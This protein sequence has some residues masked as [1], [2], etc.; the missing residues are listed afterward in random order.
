MRSLFD[1]SGWGREQMGFTEDVEVL[2]I[3]AAAIGSVVTAGL[4][5]RAVTAAFF[6]TGAHMSGDDV[7]YIQH[8]Q[9]FEAAIAEEALLGMVAQELSAGRA[10]TLVDDPAARKVITLAAAMQV[11]RPPTA[12]WS[13]AVVALHLANA[14]NV[15]R[16]DV[17]VVRDP[18]ACR[19]SV[20]ELVTHARVVVQDLRS[21]EANRGPG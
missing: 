2:D 10:P 12:R 18:V 14:L 15:L 6:A 19:Y 16:V 9:F 5:A 4:S 20:E 3:A 7:V 11:P 1:T 17:G 13:G 21:A 8:I